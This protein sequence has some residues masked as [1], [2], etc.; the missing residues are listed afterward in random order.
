MNAPHDL[1][2]WRKAQRGELAARRNAVDP[3]RRRQFNRAITR[4]IVQ[5]F[6]VLQGMMVGFYQ[7]MQGEFDPRALMRV[8]RRCGTRAALPAVAQKRHP[9]QFREWWPGAGMATDACGLPV[10]DGTEVV[11]PDALLI[12]ALGFDEQGYRLGYGG[13]Y[14]DRTL[15]LCR[16]QPL[17]IGVAFEL[18]RMASIHP[19][20]HD[21]PMD[22]IVTEVGV[23]HAGP[24]GLD[25]ILLPSRVFE[26]AC[27]I[28]WR[29]DHARHEADAGAYAS[30][31]C[32][33]HEID[34]FYRDDGDGETRR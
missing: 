7:P 32:Y 19:Q 13:G 2:Q 33:A 21:V 23:Y 12:P 20:C 29:R 24:A 4:L 11:H 22:F 10:P 14:F 18:S 27:E 28:I 9:L 1:K 16:P 6:P 3:P 34:P 26:L 30:P 15:A 8:L 31:P 17:K 25:R 5:G